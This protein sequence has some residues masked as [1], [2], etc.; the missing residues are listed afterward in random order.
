MIWTKDKRL[1]TN[2]LKKLVTWIYLLLVKDFFNKFKEKIDYLNWK[3]DDYLFRQS[4][5]F[6]FFYLLNSHGKNC[7][8][9]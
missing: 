4:K 7:L 6:I 1:F 8:I 5:K 2:Y 3:S 9:I